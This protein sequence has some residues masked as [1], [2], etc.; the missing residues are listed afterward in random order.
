MEGGV[1]KLARL[2]F[3]FGGGNAAVVVDVSVATDIGY[4]RGAV[5]IGV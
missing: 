4:E 2:A 1:V 5:L 3:V